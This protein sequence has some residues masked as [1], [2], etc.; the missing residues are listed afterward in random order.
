MNKTIRICVVVILSLLGIQYVSAQQ[1]IT[2]F[3]DT[4]T[5][6]G[7]YTVDTTAVEVKSAAVFCPRG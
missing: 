2:A 1:T 3:P 5:A 6:S 4:I 7:H